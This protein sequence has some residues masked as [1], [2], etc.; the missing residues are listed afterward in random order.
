MKVKTDVKGG[1]LLGL[2]F[3]NIDV[4]I[5]NFGGGCGC[6]GNQRGGCKN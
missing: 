1:G 6:G 3:V 2:I 4:D 5:L